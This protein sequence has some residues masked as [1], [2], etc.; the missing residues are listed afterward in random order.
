MVIVKS[1][2][3]TR[4]RRV[5]RRVSGKGRW[6]GRGDA[7]NLETSRNY[8]GHVHM[9]AKIVAENRFPKAS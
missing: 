6:K 5:N 7:R 9:E 4:S 2:A 1:V 8:F 3:I